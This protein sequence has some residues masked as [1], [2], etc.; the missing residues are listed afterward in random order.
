MTDENLNRKNY[1][2]VALLGAIV[3]GVVVARAT[4]ALP[5]ILSQMMAGMMENMMNRMHEGG[6][7]FPAMCQK[8]VQSFAEAHPDDV[9]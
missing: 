3:G 7:P 2:L 4:R 8:M 6:S 5:K 9:R 1:I